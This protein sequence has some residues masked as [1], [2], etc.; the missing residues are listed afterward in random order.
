MNTTHYLIVGGG[1]TADAACKG[2]RDFD[3][4]GA[5]TVVGEESHPPYAR[6]P[7]SKALWKG[8]DETTIWRGTGD[9]AVQLRLGRTIVA[10]DPATRRATDNQGETYA[11]ERLL[12]ATGGRPRRLPFGDD[13]V[14]YFRTLDD[15]RRLRALAD[16][17][18]ASS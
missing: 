14:I 6:P 3:P 1:L 2:I 9:L 18:I 15:Y 4:G 5:I 7:L 12:L 17:D 10:L 13:E 16:A 8:E 11:Y